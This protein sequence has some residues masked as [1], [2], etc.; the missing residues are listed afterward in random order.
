M[1]ESGLQARARWFYV[2]LLGGLAAGLGGVLTG[3][4]L[5]DE[6]WLQL[7]MAAALG[8]V[9]TQLAFLGH[10]ASHRQILA[11][12]PGNDRVGRFLAVVAVGISYSWWMDKHTRHHA[13]PNKVGKDPDIA[14]GALA[15]VEDDAAGRRGVAGRF[16][17]TAGA[18]THRPTRS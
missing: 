9:L 3:V 17:P 1:R 12:G 7:L 5:L 2:L 16:T 11:S 8:M 10:E 15:F 18:R 14:T 6:S 13:N 4:L